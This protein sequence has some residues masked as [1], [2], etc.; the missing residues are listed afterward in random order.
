MTHAP[1]ARTSPP[2]APAPTGNE[3]LE[4]KFVHIQEIF[5]L[6]VKGRQE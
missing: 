6:K 5:F 4:Q 3:N 2:P 1:V